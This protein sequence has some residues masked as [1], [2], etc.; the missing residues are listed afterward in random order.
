M[1]PRPRLS[2]QT[3]PCPGVTAILFLFSTLWFLPFLKSC[4]LAAVLLSLVS[5]LLPSRARL[6]CELWIASFFFF[7][8]QQTRRASRTALLSVSFSQN[9]T[10]YSQR[11]SCPQCP[12]SYDRGQAPVIVYLTLLFQ[13][14]PRFA[15]TRCT[16]MAN[17]SFRS[18][19]IRSFEENNRYVSRQRD[20]FAIRKQNTPGTKP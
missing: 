6:A 19:A 13:S 16:C 3:T 20:A 14:S 18:F 9:W 15:A 1:L 10:R 12:A 7:G 11:F 17:S 4:S 5:L 8:F 2:L